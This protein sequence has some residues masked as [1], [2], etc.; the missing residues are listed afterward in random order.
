[1][2]LFV[3]LFIVIVCEKMSDS[4]REQCVRKYMHAFLPSRLL[5]SRQS[6]AVHLF[7]SEDLFAWRLQALSFREVELIQDSTFPRLNGLARQTISP[8]H[9]FLVG[10]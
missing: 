6:V 4:S 8:F 3:L 9:H 10:V 2:V 7:R 5:Q 1:M